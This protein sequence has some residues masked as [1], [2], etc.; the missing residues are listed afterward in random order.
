[1]DRIQ[2]EPCQPW[3]RSQLLGWLFRPPHFSSF[4]LSCTVWGFLH[5]GIHKKT[6]SDIAIQLVSDKCSSLLAWKNPKS[7]SCGFWTTEGWCSQVLLAPSHQQVWAY[8]TVIWRS[9]AA[10]ILER[11]QPSRSSENFKQPQG[12]ANWTATAWPRYVWAPHNP[13]NTLGNCEKVKTICQ[14]EGFS[15]TVNPYS[16]FYT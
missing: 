3:V 6:E 10:K 13:R 12:G 8:T 15:Q 1:M 7:K 2:Q 4:C 9:P 11:S 16:L 5:V 14:K